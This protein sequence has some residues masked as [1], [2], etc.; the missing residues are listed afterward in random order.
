MSRAQR[1]ALVGT[2]IVLDTLMFALALGAAYATRFASGLF[3]AQPGASFGVYVVWMALALP[4][5]LLLCWAAQLY[6]LGQI[7]SDYKEFVQVIKAST[8]AV[9]AL[10]ILSFLNPGAPLSRGW[11]LLSWGLVIVL[12]TGARLVVRQAIVRQRQRGRLVTRTLII[13]V[14]EYAKVIARQLNGDR[15]AGFQVVGFLDDYLPAGAQVMGGLE[16]L[17]TPNDLPGLARELHITEAVVLP[18]ALSWESL[19]NVILGIGSAGE[20]LEVKLFPS[21]YELLTSNVRVSQQ[22][23]IPLLSIEKVRLTG[24]DAALKRALDVGLGALLLILAAPL[25]ALIA[26]ALL[27]ADGAPILDRPTVVGLRGR[28]FRTIKFR[29]GLLGSTRRSLASPLAPAS[30]HQ[31]HSSDLGRFLY[32]TGL[33]KLPQLVDVLRGTMSLVGPRT[34]GVPT[35]ARSNPWRPSIATVR[36]GMTG[37]WAVAYAPTPEEEERQAVSYIRNW[38]FWLDMQILAQTARRILHLVHDDV[39]HHE[40]APV[41]EAQLDIETR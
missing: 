38:T 29:T 34:A 1:R 4:L 13:G 2:L 11:V 8:F 14:T 35:E 22:A 12:V 7:L 10:I 3:Q 17:G 31:T 20:A 37:A 32:R 39:T 24:V 16:V 25:M 18:N 9:L 15:R 33:D 28:P 26:L 30:E 5:W 23:A 21:Y 41:I 19:Q 6:D 27:V 36:P 40:A